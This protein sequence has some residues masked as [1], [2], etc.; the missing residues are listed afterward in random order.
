M[1]G[2]F[3]QAQ[4]AELD[5]EVFRLLE[6]PVL[7]PRYNIAPTQD[8]AVIRQ[9]PSG[10]RV[11]H[12]LRWGLIPSW[13]SDPAI[14][15][16]MINA[17]AETVHSKRAFEKPFR[18]QRCLIPADGF[19]EWKK[20]AEGKQPF[21]IH[22]RD[23][24]PF[25]FAGLWDRWRDSSH[26]DVDSFTIITTT[27][28]A[29]LAPIHDRMPAILPSHS[30][31]A[32]LDGTNRDPERLGALLGPYPEEELATYSVSR[33]VNKPSNEGPECVSPAI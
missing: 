18:R 1:C 22:R 15:N 24:K 31:D 21:Y 20:T 6:L 26:G 33:Y 3:T 10:E 19:Y 27:P 5:R 25:A 17:R 11:M 8:V 32:W 2:R 23:G 9:R 12:F 28:N 16:R 7:E 14:G 30:F 13:A 29:L 4:I